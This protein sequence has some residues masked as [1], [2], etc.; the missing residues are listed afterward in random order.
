MNEFDPTKREHI[1]LRPL[2]RFDADMKYSQDYYDMHL[3][4]SRYLSEEFGIEDV[5]VDRYLSQKAESIPGSQLFD[6]DQQLTREQM[7]LVLLRVA[8]PLAENLVEDNESFY[9][10]TVRTARVAMN[11][12]NSNHEVDK[13]LGDTK[14]DSRYRC[15]ESPNC[16]IRVTRLALTNDVMQ[17]DFQSMDYH[18]SWAPRKI[19]R[20]VAKL[21]AAYS[22]GL[23]LDA[24]VNSLKNSYLHR[25]RSHELPMPETNDN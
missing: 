15:E 5:V 4:L 14:S 17:V 11:I 18:E 6:V 22:L 24:E 16:P 23:L 3:S 20:T 19:S 10:W 7:R 9:D 25:C 21:D 2:Y 13:C 1:N 8:L 12:E